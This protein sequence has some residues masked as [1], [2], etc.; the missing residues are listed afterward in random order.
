AYLW[1][2]AIGDD[3]I[4]PAGTEFR[5]R[6]TG[7][8]GGLD[9]VTVLRQIRAHDFTNRSVIVYDQNPQGIHCYFDLYIGRFNY[10]V[11]NRKVDGKGV[12]LLSLLL[13]S[14]VPAWR[15]IIP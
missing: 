13:I 3:E 1:H 15:R 9:R 11:R 2:G 8:G 10:F 4:E 6:F 5:H 7:I 14:I 12:P